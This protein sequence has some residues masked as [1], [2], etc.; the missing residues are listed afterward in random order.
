MK[1]IIAVTITI[2]LLSTIG[3]GVR[4]VVEMKSDYD[5]LI[6]ESPAAIE[7]EV[8]SDRL[9]NL[10]EEVNSGTWRVH[11]QGESGLEDLLEALGMNKGIEGLSEFFLYKLN[12]F[13]WSDL[14]RNKRTV[15]IA[16]TRAGLMPKPAD[17]LFHVTADF[18]FGVIFIDDDL[19][20]FHQRTES[21]ILDGIL[22]TRTNGSN[23]SEQATAFAA[24]VF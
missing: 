19:V 17:G 18:D 11:A 6:S 15:S 12:P 20:A 24:P 9:K 22:T 8:E 16:D 7:V 1:K 4:F 23:Q 3:F 21:G 5:Q 13:D 14:D 2:L 10:R